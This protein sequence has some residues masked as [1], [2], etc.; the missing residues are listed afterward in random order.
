M[1]QKECRNCAI[2]YLLRTGGKRSDKNL[3]DSTA[4]IITVVGVSGL[5][6]GRQRSS[7]RKVTHY[8]TSGVTLRVT[9]QIF[10]RNLATNCRPRPPVGP[11]RYPVFRACSAVPGR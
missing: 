2:Y 3:N 10:C 4:S 8:G 5:G 9:S 7:V 6:R 1:S 11:T